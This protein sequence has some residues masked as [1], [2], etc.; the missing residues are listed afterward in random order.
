MPY[1]L[2]P[3]INVESPGMWHEGNA[4][5]AESIYSIDRSPPPVNYDK[6]ILKPHSLTH[7]ETPAH[8][9]NDGSRFDYYY[10]NHLNFFYE[11]TLVLRPE[12]NYYKPLK[13]SKI[14]QWQ[15]Y[16]DQTQNRIN[17]LMLIKRL[18]EVPKGK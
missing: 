14:Y 3:L 17:K 9:K 12:E 6:H 15:I 2:S 16:K 5:E 4:Y 18:P 11:S 10:H 8:T 13:S 1:V 7:L